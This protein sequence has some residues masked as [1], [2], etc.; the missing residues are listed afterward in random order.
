M[1]LQNKKKGAQQIKFIRKKERQMLFHASNKNEGM[2]EMLIYILPLIAIVL[3][4]ARINK[5]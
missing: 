2:A 3:T 1:A 4:L 5:K